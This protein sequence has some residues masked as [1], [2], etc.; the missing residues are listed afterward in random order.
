MTILFSDQY[1]HQFSGY[2]FL[3]IAL[4]DTPHPS[5]SPSDE[6]SSMLDLVTMVHHR[7]RCESIGIEYLPCQLI[8]ASWIVSIECI[9][10]EREGLESIQL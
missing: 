3:L 5:S 1:L 8:S 10:N 6:E 4:T 2:I 7:E 9:V